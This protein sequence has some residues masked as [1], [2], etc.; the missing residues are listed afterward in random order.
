VDN[1]NINLLCKQQQ[2][3]TSCTTQAPLSALH[4]HPLRSFY[5][6]GVT[7]SCDFVGTW[8]LRGRKLTGLVPQRLAVCAGKQ[9]PA[10]V[11]D[12]MVFTAGCI[13]AH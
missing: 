11:H 12:L 7:M 6:V 5:K 2:A 10:A 3:D 9:L 1:N 4:P 13:K 8:K